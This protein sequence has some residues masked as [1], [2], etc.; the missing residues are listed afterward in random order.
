MLI[1]RIQVEVLWYLAENFLKFYINRRSLSGV[2]CF[3]NSYLILCR[4]FLLANCRCKRFAGVWIC[5]ICDYRVS[6]WKINFL[7]LKN[8]YFGI[9][10]KHFRYW[11]IACIIFTTNNMQ[12]SDIEVNEQD[13]AIVSNFDFY[14]W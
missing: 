4:L 5:K 14:W 11:S 6:R 12:Y 3:I 7:N 10:H 2:D 1:F 13:K 8:H 9:I